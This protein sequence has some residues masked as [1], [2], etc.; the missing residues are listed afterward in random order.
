M[1][2]RLPRDLHPVAWWVWALGLAAAASLSGNAAWMVLV[3]AVAT[4]VV[5]KWE[6]A[7]DSEQLRR[8]LDGELSPAETDPAAATVP[9]AVLRND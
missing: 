8:A 7:L 9:A 2:R 3:V 4:V 6:N 1:S 5:S